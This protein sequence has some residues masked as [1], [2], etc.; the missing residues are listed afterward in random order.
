MFAVTAIVSAA[1]AVPSAG[2]SPGGTLGGVAGGG[3]K[4]PTAETLVKI[5]IVTPSLMPQPGAT[6]E[7]AVVYRIEP[8]W[9]I[10]WRNS[11]D[12]G[13]PP[14]IEVVAP[15]GWTVG[16]IRWPIPTRFTSDGETTFG[17]ENGVA[18]FVPVTAPADP[19]KI[20]VS[21][22]FSL[23]VSWMVCKGVC[24]TGRSTRK[25]SIPGTLQS[26]PLPAI[27]EASRRQLARPLASAAG[28]TAVVEG[29]SGARRLVLEGPTEGAS[30][31]EF[32][33]FATPGVEYGAAQATTIDR[34]YRIV[35]PLTITPGNALGS[36]LEAAGLVALDTTLAPLGGGSSRAAAPTGPSYEFSLPVAAP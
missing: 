11:G 6:I 8:K 10:Y 14:T 15:Q 18:L 23:D 33:P 26:A 31:V 24:L 17:Y 1:G 28:A 35:V 25:A 32:F 36:T 27:I 34:R 3:A 21:A 5:D 22:E 12:S 16:P 9:H 30:R 2:K 29:E 4:E 19:S 13:L 7:L 20:G